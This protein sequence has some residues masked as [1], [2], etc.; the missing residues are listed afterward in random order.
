MIPCETV[1]ICLGPF[2]ARRNSGNLKTAEARKRD[3]SAMPDLANRN[4]RTIKLDKLSRCRFD[5]LLFL[6]TTAVALKVLCF[7]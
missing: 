7:K 4:S 2:N 6:F 5:G 3:L 1:Y